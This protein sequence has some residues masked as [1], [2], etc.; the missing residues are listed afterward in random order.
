VGLPG[1]L[2]RGGYGGVELVD[3]SRHSIDVGEAEIQRALQEP[4]EQ[5]RGMFAR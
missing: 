1:Q 2:V 3:L 4:A 5:L